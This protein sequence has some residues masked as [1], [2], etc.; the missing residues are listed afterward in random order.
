MK[1][2]IFILLSVGFLCL[3]G[4][5][6]KDI[7]KRKQSLKLR[8]N[9]AKKP[10]IKK[11]LEVIYYETT[12]VMILQG[13]KSP[14]ILLCFSC[15]ILSIIGITL[16]TLIDNIY[17][18]IMLSFVLPAIPFV[19]I[20]IYWNNQEK[21]MNEILESALSMITT[22][23]LRGNNSFLKAV[24]E[25]IDLVQEPVKKI[26]NQFSVQTKY[27]ESSV[28]D[29]LE[30][31]KLSTHNRIFHEWIDAVIRC[32]NNQ[33]LK[34]TLPR[35][36]NKFSEEKTV[37]GEIEI[38]M[39]EPKRTFFIMLGAAIVSP[40]LLLFLNKDWWDIIITNQYGKLL[41]A[42][43]VLMIGIATVLGIKAMNTQIGDENI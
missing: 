5:K 22:S 40:F 2:I 26:F 31:M 36:L 19:A 42:F 27:I 11:P 16:G 14:H 8:V 32:Q 18:G 3:I 35:I 25:N 43:H 24:E 39:E 37:M 21:Q 13:I 6:S 10:R 1:F 28:T 20:K 41:L 4:F 17:L 7:P 38:I 9:K 12:Q 23:Y 30:N 34:A 29:A 15:G 33:S